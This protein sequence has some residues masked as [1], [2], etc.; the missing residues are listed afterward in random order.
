MGIIPVTSVTSVQVNVSTQIRTCLVNFVR[1]VLNMRQDVAAVIKQTC[2]GDWCC[3][4]S[5]QYLLQ[6][7][8]KAVLQTAEVL[9]GICVGRSAEGYEWDHCETVAKALRCTRKALNVPRKAVQQTPFYGA[10]WSVQKGI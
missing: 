3:V 10:E 4:P 7:A 1:F 6:S 9:R 8:N 5:K 2:R